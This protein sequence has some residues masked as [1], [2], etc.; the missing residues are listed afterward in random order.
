MQRCAKM[1]TDSRHVD[2]SFSNGRYDDDRDRGRDSGPPARERSRS[3]SAER[4]ARIAA[5]N[6]ERE[7]GDGANNA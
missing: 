5:W 6:A 7:A 1:H 4:R 3:G 2:L